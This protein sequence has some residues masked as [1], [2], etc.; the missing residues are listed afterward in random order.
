MEGRG[1]IGDDPDYEI[2]ER[3]D[4]GTQAGSA[5]PDPSPANHR[6]ST[7][8]LTGRQGQERKTTN[9]SLTKSM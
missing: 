4:P 2:F 8:A 7:T 1:I 6:L 9:D 5:T 3:P